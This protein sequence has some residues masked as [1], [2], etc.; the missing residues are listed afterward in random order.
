MSDLY[1]LFRDYD[2]VDA[3]NLDGGSS[4]ELFYNGKVI[5]KLWNWAGERYLPTAFVVMPE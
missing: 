5:N 4:T 3:A 2:A 1:N